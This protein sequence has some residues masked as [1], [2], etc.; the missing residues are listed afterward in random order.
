MLKANSANRGL[1]FV[2]VVVMA[3]AMA[4]TVLADSNEPL[5]VP[6]EDL[7]M[8][9]HLTASMRKHLKHKMKDSFADYKTIEADFKFSQNLKPLLPHVKSIIGTLST[10][11]LSKNNTT[12]SSTRIKLSQSLKAQL[13]SLLNSNI[14]IRELIE[15]YIT[16]LTMEGKMIQWSEKDLSKIFLK[17]CQRAH[18]WSV[19]NGKLNVEE[20]IRDSDRSYWREVIQMVKEIAGSSPTKDGQMVD[21]N[22]WRSVSKMMKEFAKS[23]G[24][25]TTTS[26]DKNYWR[27]IASLIKEFGGNSQKF[28][29][30][31]TNSQP[32]EE[33]VK[34]WRQVIAMTKDLFISKPTSSESVSNQEYW[35][36]ITKLIKEFGDKNLKHNNTQYWRRVLNMTK[37]VARKKN[38]KFQSEVN[39]WKRVSQMIKQFSKTQ[40]KRRYRSKKLPRRLW[41]KIAQEVDKLVDLIVK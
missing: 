23:R 38:A 21:V 19:K 37:Q 20:S 7:L 4:G 31:S 16:D 33:D 41:K 2:L 1:L 13:K 26:P 18:Q 3:L 36:S 14:K 10:T 8:I 22:Y 35:R 28:N 30:S 17:L 12:L 34:Y 29:T 5:F 9:R 15:N 27:Q 25:Q 11:T 40:N 24:L 6:H 32:N 39:Y